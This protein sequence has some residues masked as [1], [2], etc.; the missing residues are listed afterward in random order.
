M[1]RTD[2]IRIAMAK[3][4]WTQETL[5]DEAGLSR[6][7]VSD[8]VNEKRSPTLDSLSAV[9]K[10]LDIPLSDLFTEAEAA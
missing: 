9:A 2:L 3:K 7:T 10:A 5:A 8:L 4:N 6:P 1:Y